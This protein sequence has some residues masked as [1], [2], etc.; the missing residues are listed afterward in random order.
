MALAP[1]AKAAPPIAGD[2]WRLSVA[3]AR[4]DGPIRIGFLEFDQL[5]LS[6]RVDT[7][8]QFRGLTINISAPF[9]R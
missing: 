6:Y 5:G 9:S 2:E 8:G 1:I 3:L 7:S 4:S